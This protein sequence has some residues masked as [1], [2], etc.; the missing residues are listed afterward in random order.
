MPAPM[1]NYLKYCISGRKK[2]LGYNSPQFY[3]YSQ[4]IYALI[5]NLLMDS[6]LNFLE[7][8]AILDS[9]LLAYAIPQ[10]LLQ[11]WRVGVVGSHDVVNKG[12]G[13]TKNSQMASIAWCHFQLHVSHKAAK[14]MGKLISQSCGTIQLA[15]CLPGEMEPYKDHPSTHECPTSLRNKSQQKQP[16]TT[17]STNA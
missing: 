2:I 14:S 17:F 9:F 16:M 6:Q 10:A 8:P 4:S 15:V 11:R 3:S 7:L 13:N 12:Y 5:D 1:H